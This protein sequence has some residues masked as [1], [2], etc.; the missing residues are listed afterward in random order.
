[1]RLALAALPAATSAT[2]SPTG[3]KLRIKGR[4]SGGDISL[5]QKALAAIGTVELVT[6]TPWSEGE[7]RFSGVPFKDLSAA[8]GFAG[9][10][11]VLRALN[12][13]SVRTTVETLV[14]EALVAFEI[15]GRPIPV[16]EK[17]PLWVVFPWSRRR[18]LDEPS[19]Q[20]LSIW[21]L[22]TIEIP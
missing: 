4:I 17:G 22:Q 3:F 12:E 11:V 5:D 9:E 16:R 6:R 13:Y 19:T 20:S 2:A 7:L 21:Q 18:D 1:M 10:D 14:E 8:L 15:G